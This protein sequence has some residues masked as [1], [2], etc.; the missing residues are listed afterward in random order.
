M[1]HIPNL[2]RRPTA[3]KS[4]PYID[5]LFDYGSFLRGASDAIG[6]L[7]SHVAH[8]PIAVVGSGVGGLV[9]AYELLRAGARDV[10]IFE[11][12]ARPGGRMYSRPFSASHPA[13]SVS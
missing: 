9:A 3:A 7:P 11:A 13:L 10:T 2:R 8:E 6:R 5:T 4:F 12:S 1:A